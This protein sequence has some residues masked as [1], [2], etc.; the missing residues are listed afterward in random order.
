MGAILK[1]QDKSQIIFAPTLNHISNSLASRSLVDKMIRM[2][3]F[4][5][6]ASSFTHVIS[7]QIKI[8]QGIFNILL[9]L[10]LLH[11]Y[12]MKLLL[13]CSS[14]GRC[15]WLSRHRGSAFTEWRLPSLGYGGSSK[16][17]R[18]ERVILFCSGVDL[19]PWR[20][21]H[22]KVGHSKYF[23]IVLLNSECRFG[24]GERV[25]LQRRPLMSFL[26]SLR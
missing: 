24:R 12:L 9:L 10:L 7:A 14:H 8:R 20:W 22:T 13:F 16:I 1:T 25:G 3:I 26:V 11:L 4:Q 15:Q 18:F 17:V 19:K 2:F 23:S 5:L 21:L 6:I